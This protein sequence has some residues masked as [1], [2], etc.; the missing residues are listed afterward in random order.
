MRSFGWL[1][2]VS[3]LD[4]D[5][6]SSSCLC[7]SPYSS[8]YS[9]PQGY[10]TAGLFSKLLLNTC[11][12]KWCISSGG[13]WYNW[14]AA[15]AIRLLIYF[16]NWCSKHL[17]TLLEGGTCCRL[18]MLLGQEGRHIWETILLSESWEETQRMRKLLLPTAYFF[19]LGV[20]FSHSF[21]KSFVAYLT[22][23]LARGGWSSQSGKEPHCSMQGALPLWRPFLTICFVVFRHR[24]L[25]YLGVDNWRCG[26]KSNPKDL[27]YGPCSKGHAVSPFCCMPT[28]WDT[29]GSLKSFSSSVNSNNAM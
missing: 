22:S 27:P 29:Q 7:S 20:S 28:S 9:C 21:S 15:A 19:S 17:R 14:Q 4:Q 8:S 10:L 23:C 3:L 1:G 2:H 12:W 11:C 6:W 18:G 25:E 5:Y 13:I 26:A 16:I 24:P